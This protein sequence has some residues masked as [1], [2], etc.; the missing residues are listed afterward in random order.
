MRTRIL[1]VIGFTMAALSAAPASAGAA[2]VFSEIMYDL[3][4]SDTK[5]EWVEVINCGPDV[6][7]ITTGSGSGSWRFN[8]G[9]NHIL[10]D[11]VQGSATLNP[12]DVLL[13][14]A[15]AP[16]FLAEHP[17]VSGAVMDT[18]MNL[19]NTSSTTQLIDGGG[20]VVASA[21]Y[22]SGTGAKGNGRT[23]ERP[24]PCGSPAGPWQ[25]SATDGGTPG[26]V[27]AQAPP[28]PEPA[29]PPPAQPS[30]PNPQPP[31]KPLPRVALSELLPDPIGDDAGGE[32]IELVNLEDKEADVN[33]LMLDDSTAGGAYTFPDKTIVEPRGYLAVARA[34]SK[35]ALTNA[36]DEVKLMWPSGE[37]IEV[38]TFGKAPEG[39]SYAKDAAGSWR[40]TYQPTRAAA[41][42]FAEKPERQKVFTPLPQQPPDTE[43]EYEGRIENT[44]QPPAQLETA[45]QTPPSAKVAQTA[46]RVP[47]QNALPIESSATAP[48]TS[49][50]L[51]ASLPNQSSSIP[52]WLLGTGILVGGAIV[53]GLVSRFLIRTG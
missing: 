2:L 44:S 38:V 1:V 45:P 27:A 22:E 42:A 47:D 31:P 4:G 41:N 32:W 13:L 28:P 11:P 37:F 30:S 24:D 12:N 17:G 21:T 29:P 20:A 15:D 3:P 43:S 8:D 23:L 26:V 48:S 50:L 53:G 10:N 5:R 36:G 40:W 34:D 19:K 33:G 14:T 7:S 35:I 51:A 46:P 25:E 6:V 16:T 39:A 18:V 49:Q 52:P 9:A